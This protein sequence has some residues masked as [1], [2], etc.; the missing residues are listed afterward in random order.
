M[1]NKLDKNKNQM[2]GLILNFYFGLSS[3]IVGD[4]G[5]GKENLT[6]Q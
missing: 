3:Q 1:I 6:Y 2:K 5:L 4:R